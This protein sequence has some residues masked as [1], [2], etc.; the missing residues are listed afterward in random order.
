MKG[1]ISNGIFSRSAT[2]PTA[3]AF[4]RARESSPRVQLDAAAQGQRD[5]VPCRF[6]FARFCGHGELE[7]S[8]IA[9]ARADQVRYLAGATHCS[10]AM[11]ISAVPS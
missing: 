3:W 5:D 11:N 2:L 7:Q 10:S 9:H 6:P 8:G 4:S 1:V